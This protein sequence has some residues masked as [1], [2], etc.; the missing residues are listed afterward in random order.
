MIQDGQEFVVP[1]VTKILGVI[2]KGDALVQW[3]AN[4]VVACVKEKISIEEV[5]SGEHVHE[6]ADDCK[7]AFRRKKQEAADVGTESHQIL[8]GIVR[9]RL[10]DITS[11]FV[12]PA[13]DIANAVSN[14]INAGTEWLRQSEVV[15]LLVERR[16]YSRKHGFSGTL[17]LLARVKGKVKVIDYKSSKSLY[18]EYHLQ[19][20]AYA[21]AYEEETGERIQGRILV[22]LGKEDGAFETRELPF[23]YK[24]EEDYQVFLATKQLYDW[25]QKNK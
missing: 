5:Y 17:D 15:P 19:T 1:S 16:I 23:R 9:A 2:S 14:C 21:M 24:L 7:Y 3:A 22:R 11:E 25:Q 4:Q 20:A 18:S 12:V 6:I 8:E 13:V 10:E